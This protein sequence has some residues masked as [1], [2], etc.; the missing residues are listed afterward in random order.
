MEI[1]RRNRLVSANAVRRQLPPR[2]GFPG[3][4]PGKPH[5][6]DPPSPAAAHPSSTSSAARSEPIMA[7]PPGRTSPQ[8]GP[9]KRRG[10]APTSPL[11]NAGLAKLSPSYS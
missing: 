8:A 11:P 1:R 7:G 2:R 3:T 6:R 10:D 9:H 4:R 5:A